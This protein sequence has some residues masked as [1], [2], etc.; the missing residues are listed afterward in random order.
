MSTILYLNGIV[1][2]R[3]KF[4]HYS[5][6][7][8]YKTKIVRS[9]RKVCQKMEQLRSGRKL[10]KTLKLPPFSSAWELGTRGVEHVTEIIG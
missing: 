5:L 1:E 7:M 10:E 6:A 8:N 3:N 4:K 9:I 2:N